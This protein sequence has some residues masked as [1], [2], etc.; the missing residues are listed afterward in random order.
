[1]ARFNPLPNILNMDDFET[2]ILQN[3]IA[4]VIHIHDFGAGTRPVNVHSSKLVSEEGIVIS[5]DI[6][7]KIL[8]GEDVEV[9][10]NNPLSGHFTVHN[11]FRAGKIAGR[12][13]FRFGKTHS[14]AF[15]SLRDPATGCIE[16]IR[17]PKLDLGM[18]TFHA[19]RRPIEDLSEQL[20]TLARNKINEYDITTDYG[21]AQRRPFL[22]AV[23]AAPPAPLGGAAGPIPP[24]FNVPLLAIGQDALAAATSAQSNA[25]DDAALA[26]EAHRVAVDAISAARAAALTSKASRS[27]AI[28]AERAAYLAY[29]RGIS[30]RHG[31]MFGG[32]MNKA[33][34]YQN[35]LKYLLN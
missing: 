19:V 9:D 16:L 32:Y 4:L 29:V 10:P 28:A 2:Y 11:M 17:F 8:V 14:K 12:I 24:A 34:K 7:L 22:D 26:A 1:M 3:P 13:H 35:K 33:N 20:R 30:A 27:N 6:S 23:A 31:I 18:F 5:S 15:T 25:G 21:R